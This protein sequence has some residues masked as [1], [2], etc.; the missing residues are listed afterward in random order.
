M[1]IKE[2]MSE[3]KNRIVIEEVIGRYVNLKRVGKNYVGLCPFHR[4]KTP[5]FTVAPEKGFY[6]CFGCGKSGDVFTFVMEIE[7]IS[8]MEAVR[9]LAKEARV[10]IDGVLYRGSKADKMLVTNLKQINSEAQKFFAFHLTKSER[11]KVGMDYLKSRRVN[12]MVAEKFKFGMAPDSKKALY[13]YLKSKFFTDDTIFE[14]KL[15]LKTSSGPMDL[16]RGRLTLPIES[17]YGEIVGF[18]GRALSDKE[19]AKYINLPETV[20]FRKRQ[21][22]FGFNHAKGR[23]KE[24]GRVFLVEGYFDVISLHRCGIENVCGVMGTAL[25]V[26]QV[27][28]FSNIANTVYLFFDSDSAGVKAVEKAIPLILN[29]SDLEVKLVKFSQKDPDEFVKVLESKG[30]K[31]DEDM[32]LKNSCDIVDF[33]LYHNSSILE[34]DDKVLKMSFLLK[35]FYFVSLMK[36]IYDKKEA[37]RKLSEAIG[38]SESVVSSEFEKYQ[39]KQRMN[40][41]NVSLAYSE[42]SNKDIEIVIAYMVSKDNSLFDILRTE[43]DIESMK[44]ETA[45]VYLTFLEDYLLSEEVSEESVNTLYLLQ[46]EVES[47]ATNVIL[48]S[49]ESLKEDFEFLLALYKIRRIRDR[50][51][52]I[53]S[54]IERVSSE[55]A[56]REI[57]E[58]LLEEKH[59]LTLEEKKI[60]ENMRIAY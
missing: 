40:A 13:S 26:E 20:L 30:E 18:A 60:K 49:G 11:G 5:S 32:L 12:K 3:I 1:N 19:S 17:E 51:R 22:L 48:V 29:N 7:K 33:F 34:S 59:L 10:D 8:F 41:D 27:K 55:E 44:N 35:M 57:V 21:I 38:V 23:I 50:K 2:V 52:E 16:F 9:K 25:T 6:H 37:I 39:S 54:I 53:Q 42:L 4:E 14:S 36:N 47:K 56:D 24:K 45:R 31:V 28:L 58:E 46:S 43:V 15:V